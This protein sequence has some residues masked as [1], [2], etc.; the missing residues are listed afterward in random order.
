M[1]C[2]HVRQRNVLHGSDGRRRKST[3]G[4]DPSGKNAIGGART[5]CRDY[6]AFR[7]YTVTETAERLRPNRTL[8]GLRVSVGIQECSRPEKFPWRI[9]GVGKSTN[10]VQM[11]RV[12][13][14]PW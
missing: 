4:N 11:P 3:L 2:T 1:V 14:V 8:D 13:R 12:S 5:S 9:S 7:P 10:P 6:K